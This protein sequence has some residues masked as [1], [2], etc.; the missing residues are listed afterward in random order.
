MGFRRFRVTGLIKG[1][2]RVQE[3]FGVW[4]GY[5]GFGLRFCFGT[6]DPK[7]KTIR[8]QGCG[9]WVEGFQVRG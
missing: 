5:R 8:P 3:G 2:T 7:Q 4:G 1:L 9:S 6:L